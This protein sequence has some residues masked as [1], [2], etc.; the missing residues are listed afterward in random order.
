MGYLTK[1]LLLAESEAV[2]QVSNFTLHEIMLAD[3]MGK[4]AIFT[5][6]RRD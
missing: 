6:L 3:F 1:S 2:I 5:V 4:K